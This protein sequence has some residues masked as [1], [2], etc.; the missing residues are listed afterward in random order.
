M[1]IEVYTGEP[2][3]LCEELSTSIFAPRYIIFFASLA[4]DGQ[5]W[6]SDCRRAEPLIRKKF[7]SRRELT[8]LVYAGQRDEYVDPVEDN[9]ESRSSLGCSVY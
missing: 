6:C 9:R 2:R 5:S 3:Q 1:P 8:T 4:E 7:A